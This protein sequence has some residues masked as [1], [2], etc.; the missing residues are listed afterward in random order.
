[1]EHASVLLLRYANSFSFEASINRTIYEVILPYFIYLFW[2]LFRFDVWLCVCRCVGLWIDLCDICMRDMVRIHVCMGNKER[3]E[4]NRSKSILFLK[5]YF[6]V[7]REQK[8][9][10]IYMTRETSIPYAFFFLLL[11]SL[12]V[13]VPF[14]CCCCCISYSVCVSYI[15]KSS[16]FFPQRI[17]VSHSMSM[18]AYKW[19]MFAAQSQ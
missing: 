7:E 8:H 1:M 2:R 17:S 18:E 12:L 13:P 16:T 10:D 3:E 19:N 5:I 4:W 15:V 9:R 6:W 11:F 14:F